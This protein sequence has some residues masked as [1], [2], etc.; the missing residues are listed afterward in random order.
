MNDFEVWPG[1]MEGVGRNEFVQAASALQLTSCWMTP[2]IRITGSLPSI[3]KMVREIRSYLDSGLPTVVQ[4]MGSDPA[5]LGKCAHQI[6]ENFPG[7]AGINLNCGCP[8]NRVVGHD[9]GGGMLKNPGEIAGFCMKMAEFLPGKKISVK[10]RSG[11]AEPG[12]MEIFLPALAESGSVSK[13]FFHYRTVKELYSLHA[14]PEREK[15][16]ARAVELCGS[17]PL[18]ANGDIS[19]V[20]EAREIVRNTGCAGVMI[21]RPWIKDPFL[22]RR[23]YEEVPEAAEGRE[24]FFSALQQSGVTGGALIE[25][26]KMLWGVESERFRKIISKEKFEK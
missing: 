1:P 12:D 14:L 26:A 7:I 23:F 20:A 6:V 5:L 3:G 9:S 2:F 13:I 16:I 19:S 15:R 10:I 21:A 11:F 18:I 17:V 4:L 24:L 25:I 8:S 22:L